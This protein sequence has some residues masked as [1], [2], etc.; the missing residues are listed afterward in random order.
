MSRQLDLFAPDLREP[1]YRLTFD[2]AVNIHLALWRG[3]F[4]H[5][6]AARYQCNPGRI[7]EVR[8]G[9]LHPGSEAEAIRR[10]GMPPA[11]VIR[12]KH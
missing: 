10:F 1:S 2:D 7:S 6:I 8:Y 4:V 12:K 3:E 11:W 9:D 5:R